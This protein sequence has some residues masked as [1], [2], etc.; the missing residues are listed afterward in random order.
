LFFFISLL[1]LPFGILF[2][3]QKGGIMNQDFEKNKKALLEKIT[4]LHH[5]DLPHSE[6]LSKQAFPDVIVFGALSP[7][8]EGLID[9]LEKKRPLEFFQDPGKATDYCL[10]H[11]VSNVILDMDLPT[12][13]KMA[14]DVFT[15]VRMMKTTLHFILLTKSPQSTPVETLAAQGV[16]VLTKPFGTD[17]LFKKLTMLPRI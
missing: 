17:M 1:W 15:T 2:H 8:M 5:S 14:T 11:E 7:F 3:Y 12:D 16:E 4:A 9:A 13:W 6:P 10:D